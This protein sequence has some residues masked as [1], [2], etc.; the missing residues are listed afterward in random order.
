[1]EKLRFPF[2]SDAADRRPAVIAGP[3]SAETEEQ[4]LDTARQLVAAGF[5]IFRAGLW[6]PRTKPG[7]FEGVGVAGIAWLQRVK[8]E[9]GM[10]VATEVATR[11]H[12]AAALEGGID[13]LWIGARTSANPFAVQEI[14]DALQVFEA[15]I[16]VLVKNPVSPC[17]SDRKT[18][19]AAASGDAVRWA[20]STSADCGRRFFQPK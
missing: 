1:M 15:D 12:V 3:C 2:F 14:A 8:R 18:A 16:P 11:E 6:K 4:T 5:R 10:Y 19:A 13:L 7:G 9:T 20:H 17:G